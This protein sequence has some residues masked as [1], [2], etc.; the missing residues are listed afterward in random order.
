MDIGQ[1]S[2]ELQMLAQN[3]T[4]VPGFR[5]K[6]MVETDRLL[7]LASMLRGSLPADIQEASELLKQKEGLLNL[8]SMEAERIKK[9]AQ[10]EA[11]ALTSAA[12]EEHATKVDDS[13]VLKAAENRGEE[14]KEEAV[15]ESQQIVQDAQRRAYR[16]LQEAEASA[17]NKRD[18]ADNYAREVLF[19][20]EE[21][22]ADVL[23]QVRRGI[24]AIRIE[25]EAS[26]QKSQEVHAN[27]G[28][29]SGNGGNGQS[30]LQ[31]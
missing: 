9:A 23:G 16:T 7:E 31:A 27:L 21:E 14:L 13:E 29:G 10:E 15:Y 12:K 26:Q 25:V 28:S 19:N 17:L 24:D 22:L 6:V 8:A 1:I 2:N 11:S 5:R 3:G 18:G 30:K 4:R 20:L